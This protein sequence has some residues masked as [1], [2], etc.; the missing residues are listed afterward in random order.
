LLGNG[1]VLVGL[2]HEFLFGKGNNGQLII[3]HGTESI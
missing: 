1:Q 3:E 2:P